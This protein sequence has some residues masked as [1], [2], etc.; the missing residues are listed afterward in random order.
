MWDRTPVPW[1]QESRGV[2]F[3]PPR[4]GSVGRLRARGEEE[5]A[6]VGRCRHSRL[7]L[8]GSVAAWCPSQSPATCTWEGGA[9]RL[10][11]VSERTVPVLSSS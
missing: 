10:G 2:G 4:G 1:E 3:C 6:S 9:R 5:E 8:E 11:S 7:S